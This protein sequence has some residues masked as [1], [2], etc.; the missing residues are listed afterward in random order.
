MSIYLDNGYLSFQGLLEKTRKFNFIIGGRGIGKSHLTVDIYNSKQLPI[1]YVARTNVALENSFSPISDFSKPDWFGKD[2]I[3]KYNNRKG[4]G[5]AYKNK[6]DLENG[7]PFI[8]GVSLS[9]FNNKTGIDFTQF[10]DVILDEFIPQR[11]AR[12]IKNEFAAYKNIMEAVYRNR[13]FDEYSKIKVWFFGNSNAITSNIIIGYRLV[14]DLYEMYKSKTEVYQVNGRDIT[15]FMPFNSPISEQKALNPFYKNL[16]ESRKRMEL[17]NE[18][19]DLEDNH[20]RHQ[21]LKEYICWVQTP[22]FTVWGHKSNGSYYVTRK[23]K[24]SAMWQNF[25]ATISGLVAW[26]KD[27]KVWFRAA[28]IEG[29][30]YYSDYEV[31]ADFLAS[32]DCVS[33]DDILG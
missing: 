13:T 11:G 28:C 14:K 33:W 19:A 17:K 23:I 7:K 25:E 18:F 24:G 29:S 2:L 16:P 32:A 30:I 15:L 9:T 4:F 3:Y 10:Y 5:V 21:N 20:I 27:Y 1:L 6:E 8:Y 12:P 22:L 31:Q 26:Q